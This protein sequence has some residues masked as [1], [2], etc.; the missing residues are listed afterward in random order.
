M[1]YEQVI[2]ESHI[3]FVM[4][5]FHPEIHHIIL[6]QVIIKVLELVYDIKPELH[7]NFKAIR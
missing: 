7:K 3:N 2:S 6:M 5:N 4:C 1:K